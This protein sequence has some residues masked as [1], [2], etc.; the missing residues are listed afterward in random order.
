MTHHTHFTVDWF[1]KYAPQWLERMSYF[2]DVQTHALEIGSYEGR[3]ACWILDNIL[4]HPLSDIICV[5][6]W[7]GTDKTLGKKTV[8]A[9]QTFLNNTKFYKDKIDVIELDSLRALTGLIVDKES[10]DLIFI[11]GDH[12]GY[13][14]LTDLVLSWPLLKVGGWLVFDDYQWE[15]EALTTYPKDAWDAFVSVKP[16]GLKWE[17]DGRQVFARKQ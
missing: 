16:S 14:A 7:D 13:S 2:K 6:V 12:E 5:D 3:S 11:D 17:V 10:F 4:I 15:H 1:T 8:R 9:K